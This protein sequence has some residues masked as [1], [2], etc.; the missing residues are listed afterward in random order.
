MIPEDLQWNKVPAH[1]PFRALLKRGKYQS[2]LFFLSGLIFKVFNEVE[3]FSLLS[4][5]Q[6]IYLLNYFFF[7]T[8]SNPSSLLLRPDYL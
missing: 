5:R 7:Q 1:L 4:F 6:V 8:H 3:N 2:I